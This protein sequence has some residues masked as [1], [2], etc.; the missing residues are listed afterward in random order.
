VAATFAQGGE[1]GYDRLTLRRG[2]S[3]LL[4]PDLDGGSAT[5]YVEE[6]PGYQ[7]VAGD[8][9]GNGTDSL[10]LF[11]DGV[12][13]IRDAAGGPY[14]A[15]HFGQ[16][17]DI[18]LLGD[19]NGDGT[20]SLGL[21]R[22]GHWYVRDNSANGPTRTFTYGLGTDLPVI[23]DWDGNG[24]TDIGVVRNKTWFQRD[25]TSSGATN[26]QFDFGLPGDR[27]LAGD[28]DHD[29]R[30]SP[31]VFRG[32]T[33]FFRVSNAS[34]RFATT[35]FGQAGD[36]PLV[37]RTPGLAPG[38]THRV[39]HDPAGPFTEHIAT[40][41]LAAASSPDVMLSG[42]RLPGTLRT[43]TMGAQAGA[44]LAINGDYFLSSGRPVHAY[45]EDGRLLQT[46][47]VLGRAF[48]LDADGTAVSMGYPDTRATLTTQSDTSTAVTAL[49]RWNSGPAT[50]DTVA[51]YTAAGA[52]LETP[53]ALREPGTGQQPGGAP[54]WRRG[55]RDD[56]QR[57]AAM[58]GRPGYRP[59]ARG[60]PR[61]LLLQRQRHVAAGSAGR[62]ARA[63]D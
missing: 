18:P 44:A 24:R 14:Q 41:D 12:W 42:G 7:P 29:G 13:L 39:V 21:F 36:V 1:L 8:T 63:T 38:V 40:I 50:G 54:G 56:R 58:R 35:T 30:D 17:G 27:R 33:W 37:R 49:P 16:K 59:G 28:W 55:Q 34:G 25:A 45:A 46:P 5:S 20:D 60:A 52:G 23:G 48:G 51:A 31:G 9:D 61:R 22:K 15:I 10:S 47:Q 53:P 2:G 32:G 4:Q 62:S 26:R 43:S 6:T 3:W 19:W 11:R 57:A